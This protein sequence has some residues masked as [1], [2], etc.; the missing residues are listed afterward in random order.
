MQTGLL[1][2]NDAERGSDTLSP[3]SAATLERIREAII[4]KRNPET[5]SQQARPKKFEELQKD[6][7]IFFGCSRPP[8]REPAVPLALLHPVFGRFVDNAKTIVP[9]SEDYAIAQ[10]LREEM[11]GFFVNEDKRRQAL[12]DILRGYDL[13]IYPGPVGGSRKETDG[14]ILIKKHPKLIVEMKNEIASGNAEPSFQAVLYYD[15]FILQN[16]L[17]EDATT[18][19][20][21]FVI[22]LAGESQSLFG[23]LQILNQK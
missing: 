8:K 14:H 19:H 12:I 2:V 6:D 7:K 23:Y 4:I 1:H 11:C 16:K 3:L 5:P 20:P 18:C 13:E 21:C 17:W 22:F 15:T 10:T 9:K